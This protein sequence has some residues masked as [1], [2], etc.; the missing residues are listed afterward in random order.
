MAEEETGDGGLEA[1]PRSAHAIIQVVVGVRP[2]LG[3]EA[4]QEVAVT[5][6]GNSNS[7]Q[8]T[9]PPKRQRSYAPDQPN[10]S[11]ARAFTFDAVLPEGASNDDVFTTTGME[12]MVEA[13]IDGYSVTFF[14]FGHTGSGKTHTIIGPRLSQAHG[15]ASS[16]MQP[17][18]AAAAAAA[19]G[20]HGGDSGDGGSGDGGGEGDGAAAAAAAASRREDGVLR[21]CVHATFAS[22]HGRAGARVVAVGA[23]C[24]EVYNDV[25]TD[26]LNHDTAAKPLQVRRTERDTF[27]CVGLTERP[28]ASA[29]AAMQCMQGALHARAT[30]AHRLNE[31]SSRSHCIMT[32]TFA[33]Q[34]LG[35]AEKG[36]AGGLRRYGKL[37]LV[38]LA[39]SERLR[40]TGTSDVNRSAVKETGHIN[41]SLFI[42]GQVLAALH[43]QSQGEDTHVPYRDSKLTQLL[44]DG[45]RD[46]GMVLMLACLGP[47]AAAAKE[48]H[49]TLHFASTAQR[50]K[51]GHSHEWPLC[52]AAL[53][54]HC[55]VLCCS[56]LRRAV[57][58]CAAPRCDAL[59]RAVMRCAA[60]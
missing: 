33:S 45:L 32:F 39:G 36:A 48:S 19:A 51:M 29:S 22:I 15:A 50:V 4:A 1:G 3:H 42:L 26:L 6:F 35:G 53:V 21:R 56:A 59:R 18:A 37:V 47:T 38:D 41:R 16:A 28:C 34:E 23:S 52:C 46:T 25:A 30:R 12:R 58:R 57:M 55:T 8:V 60:L 10:G 7:V 31:H 9:V 49:S 5:S 40:D 43:A 14:A 13:A 54:L 2:V 27:C 11:E 20:A 17:A 24:V 44:W